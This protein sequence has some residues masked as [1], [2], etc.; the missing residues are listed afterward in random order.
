[1]EIIWGILALGLGYVM[2]KFAYDLRKSMREFAN[3]N[4]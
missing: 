3:L 4:K 1:M 2:L